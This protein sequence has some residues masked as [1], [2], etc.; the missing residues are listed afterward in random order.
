VAAR[1]QERKPLL[2]LSLKVATTAAKQ[3]AEAAVETE[4]LSVMAHE[5]ENGALPLAMALAQSSSQLLE[6]QRGTVGRAQQEERIDERHI[7]AFI[8][9]VD[10]EEYVDA[11]RSEVIERVLAFDRGCVSPHRP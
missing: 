6:E 11:A 4:F 2:N 5:I 10:G 1:R 3:G 8:E 9:Q 7:N